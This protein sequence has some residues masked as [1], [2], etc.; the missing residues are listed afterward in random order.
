MTEHLIEDGRKVR[1]NPG[2]WISLPANLPHKARNVSS[3]DA[4]LL[5]AFSSANGET[6]KE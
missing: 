1:L 5:I 4:I 6:V 3:E 2:D